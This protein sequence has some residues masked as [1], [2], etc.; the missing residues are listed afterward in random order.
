MDWK[1][2]NLEKLE[3]NQNRYSNPYPKMKIFFIVF[4]LSNSQ[5]AKDLQNTQT[6][7]PNT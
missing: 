3:K 4:K 1:S 2:I 5:F 7:N 6:Q